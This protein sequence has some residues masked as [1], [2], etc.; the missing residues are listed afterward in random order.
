MLRIDF[1]VLNVP[2]TADT[3]LAMQQYSQVHRLANLSEKLS[4]IRLRHALLWGLLLRY[5][6][7]IGYYHTIRLIDHH[8]KMSDS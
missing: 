6:Q 8:E 1:S 2:V 5:K 3:K 7:P 4:E